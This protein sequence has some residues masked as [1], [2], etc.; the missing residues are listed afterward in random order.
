MTPR[1]TRHLAWGPT[2]IL[3]GWLA[4]DWERASSEGL[5]LDQQGDLE[6]APPS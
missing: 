2:G 1:S 4:P 6:V 5:S 3:P